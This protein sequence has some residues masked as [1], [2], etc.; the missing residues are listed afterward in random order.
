MMHDNIECEW[1]QDMSGV[2]SEGLE[3]QPGHWT[4]QIGFT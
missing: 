3:G 4:G 2:S 1:C